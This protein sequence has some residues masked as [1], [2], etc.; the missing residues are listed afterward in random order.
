M[1]LRTCRLLGSSPRAVHGRLRPHRGLAG[2]QLRR[3]MRGMLPAEFIG[4]GIGDGPF[5]GLETTLEESRGKEQ[6]LSG[7]L[8]EVFVKREGRWWHP[9]WHLDLASTP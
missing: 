9:A 7:R 6:T 1:A 5:S 2:S 4:I 3:A 8:T